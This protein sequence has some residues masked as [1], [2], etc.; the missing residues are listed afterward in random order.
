MNSGSPRFFLREG[1][2][3]RMVKKTVFYAA[4][5]L[6]L[7]LLAFGAGEGVVRVYL[8]LAENQELPPS[9]PAR[10]LN[11]DADGNQPAFQPGCALPGLF[12][13]S[14]GFRSRETGPEELQRRRKIMIIGESL[15]FGWGASSNATTFGYLLEDRLGRDRFAVLNAGV[16]GSSISQTIGYYDRYCGQFNPDI[17]IVFSGWNDLV[18]ATLPPGKAQAR[19]WRRP[20][21][22]SL[23]GD[24]LNFCIERTRLGYLLYRA[25]YFPAVVHS[26]RLLAYNRA[27]IDDF[28]TSLETFLMREL[29]RGKMALVLTL[30]TY[31]NENIH[32]TIDAEEY[33]REVASNTN[34]YSNP[35]TL[36]RLHRVCNDILR[37]MEAIPGVYVVDVDADFSKI[38]F[39]ER[40]S[41]FAGDIA[42]LNDRG[43]R[44][45]AGRLYETLNQLDLR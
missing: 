15:A 7:L 28:E 24:P 29:P 2:A 34:F 22:P 44:L 31:L 14:L 40:R 12:I 9:H 26:N 18:N 17:L 36:T 45:I 35:R 10:C 13:N 39:Q 30:P 1:K 27:I 25:L 5:S 21:R 4:L 20:Y 42:H 6:L 23:F 32:Q 11:K 33:N 8:A 43:N 19:L 16:P 41:L 3:N 37:S 38:P